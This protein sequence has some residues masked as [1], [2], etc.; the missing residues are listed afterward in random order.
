MNNQKPEE[1]QEL[2]TLRHFNW[3]FYWDIPYPS[4]L[5]IIISTG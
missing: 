4:V 3:I 2:C 1:Y 5:I